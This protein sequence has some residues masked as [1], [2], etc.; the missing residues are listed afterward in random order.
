MV[1]EEIIVTQL[2]ITYPSQTQYFQIVLPDDAI[3]ISAIETGMYWVISASGMATP[4]YAA[5]PSFDFSAPFRVS[6]NLKLGDLSLSAGSAA[7][8]F[9]EKEIMY[10]APGL[11][12]GDLI[13]AYLWPSMPWVQSSK[14]TAVNVHIHEGLRVIEGWFRDNHDPGGLSFQ[15]AINVYLWIKV[16][17]TQKTKHHDHCTC[18]RIHTEADDGVRILQE[19]SLTVSASQTQTGGTADITGTQQPVPVGGTSR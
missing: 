3:C 15:Y 4:A 8:V 7:D 13:G 11:L 17:N 1:T 10:E 18:P 19:L 14:K 16:G 9:F 6:N 5:A 2:T 12:P